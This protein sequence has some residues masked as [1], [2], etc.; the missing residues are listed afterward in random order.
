MER[1]V[2]GMTSAATEAVIVEAEPEVVMAAGKVVA[3]MVEATEAA[4]DA[5]TADGGCGARRR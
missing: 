3:A 4:T 1:V 2:T 5:V